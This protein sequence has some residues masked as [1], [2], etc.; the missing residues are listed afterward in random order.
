MNTVRNPRNASTAEVAAH[1]CLSPKRV[2]ELAER[3]TLTKPR[4]GHGYDLD[5]ARGEY[6]AF[7]KALASARQTTGDLSAIAERARKE[8]ELADRLALQNAVTRGELAP[9]VHFKT[10][11]ADAAD[12][13]R[14][15]LVPMA[16]RLAPKLAGLSREQAREVM[17][18]AIYDELKALK[19]GH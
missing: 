14:A 17:R 18:A 19:K 16:E 2:A 15:R 12:H 4:G 5:V 11:L 9:V 6:L 3:G 8:K 1:L 13:F 7:L 10:A